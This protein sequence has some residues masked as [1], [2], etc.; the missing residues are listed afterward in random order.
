MFGAWL[1]LSCAV[2]WVGVSAWRNRRL[3]TEQVGLAV[4][5]ALAGQNILPPVKFILFVLTTSHAPLPPPITGLEKYLLVA[6]IASELVTL[7]SLYSLFMQ[8]LKVIPKS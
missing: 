6:G 2:L 4:A 3:A 1:G 7:V 5:V 8:A